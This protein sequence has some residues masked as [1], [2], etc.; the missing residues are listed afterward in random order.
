MA[1]SQP[2][3]SQNEL[4]NTASLSA[5]MA[6]IHLDALVELSNLQASDIQTVHYI[7]FL[8]NEFVNQA[9][10]MEFQNA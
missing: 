4:L 5:Q 8:L 7:T 6:M 9:E 10:F 3:F 1:K 2:M